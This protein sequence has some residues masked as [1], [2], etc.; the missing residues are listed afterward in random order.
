MA[1]HAT[2][3]PSVAL[4][5]SRHGRQDGTFYFGYGDYAEMVSERVRT[6]D[7]SD[8]RLVVKV[9]KLYHH[10]GKTQ[11]EIAE[12]LGVSRPKVS[13]VLSEATRRGILKIVVTEPRGVHSEIEA[14]LE[15]RFGLR[16][17]I[18]VDTQGGVAGLRSL[19]AAAALYLERVVAP[20]D[21]IGISWGATLPH[22]VQS[23][24]RNRMP[25]VDVVQLI[26]GL[27]DPQDETHAGDLA[28][29][30]AMATGGSLVLLPAPGL[31]SSLKAKKILTADPQIGFAMDQ[32]RRVTVG[33]VGIGEPS[34]LALQ[35]TD[36]DPTVTKEFE[37]L[38]EAGAVGD[39]ALRFF[40]MDGKPIKAGLS[41]LVLGI[42][43]ADL[44][45]IPNV[46]GVAAGARKRDAIL[47][48]I[49]SGIVKTLVTDL[50]TAESIST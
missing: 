46:V 25:A 18:V 43:F 2:L 32:A 23:L 26:G 45:R 20:H 13:R 3:S 35:L 22:V 34:S 33:L 5:Q 9:A 29:R 16:E 47:G 38:R 6:R 44:K 15:K 17:A 50:A 49:R 31:V 24:S 36:R 37:K 48:A 10:E 41:E 1:F 28:S 19:G 12:A 8:L 21:V 27:G 30:A 7:N 40:D 11:Q 14:Q 39:I 4:A 42:E